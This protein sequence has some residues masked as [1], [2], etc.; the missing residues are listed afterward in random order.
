MKKQLCVA[1]GPSYGS[2][3]HSAPSAGDFR[4]SLLVLVWSR[5]VFVNHLPA[6]EWRAS[7]IWETTCSHLWHACFIQ[8]A[9]ALWNSVPPLPP[10]G[11]QQQKNPRRLKWWSGDGGGGVLHKLTWA[12]PP[13]L[14]PWSAGRPWAPAAPPGP[15]G[16]SSSASRS[17][18]APSP[19]HPPA[20][21]EPSPSEGAAKW[22]RGWE[23]LVFS[24]SDV[25][26]QTGDG[27]KYLVFLL[28]VRLPLLVKGHVE[29][30]QF[31]LQSSLWRHHRVLLPFAD[32][33]RDHELLAVLMTKTLDDGFCQHDISRQLTALK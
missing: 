32:K 1:G 28:G 21:S 6:D 26:S 4:T 19:L 17:S 5:R 10:L 15:S 20:S 24:W 14:W 30:F 12:Q 31:P 18:P 8:P 11:E 13:E 2:G 9:T 29:L 33:E 23:V 3:Y 25:E 27:C 7:K 22:N 16:P